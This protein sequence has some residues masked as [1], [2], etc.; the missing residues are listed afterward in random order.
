[1]VVGDLCG[2]QIQTNLLHPEKKG[3]IVVQPYKYTSNIIRDFY[4]D[5][6]RRSITYLVC[7]TPDVIREKM[8]IFYFV[9]HMKFLNIYIDIFFSRSRVRGGGDRPFDVCDSVNRVQMSFAI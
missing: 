9:F 3:Y 1:M 5:I 2:N 8:F 7:I 6:Y 4:T